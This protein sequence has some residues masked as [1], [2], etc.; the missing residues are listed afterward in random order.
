MLERCELKCVA[1]ISKAPLTKGGVCL[2]IGLSDIVKAS[3]RN[4]NLNMTGFLCYRQGYYFQVI[5]GPH[6]EVEQLIL[7]ISTDSR[8]IEPCILI[9]KSIY[10]RC[11][12]EW[13]VSVFDFIDQS[14]LFKQ[15]INN[16]KVDAA[17]L[18]EQQK[19]GIQKFYDLKNLCY[20]KNYEGKNLR[21]IAWPDFNQIRQSQTII[22]LCVKLT[23]EPYPFDQLV[24]D[25]Q[26]GSRDQIIKALDNFQNLGILTVTESEILKQQ[27]PEIIPTK[28]PSSFFG[29]IKK[30]LGMR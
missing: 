30:F 7:K 15:F 25:E 3:N 18:T 26:F 4:R 21:L 13:Q 19:L 11:F 28:T 27:E 12:P 23:K 10:K 29:A 1:Y 9:N 14:Q 16:Y 20:S 24:D 2:P 8:H 5:E 22:D 6:K 17:S